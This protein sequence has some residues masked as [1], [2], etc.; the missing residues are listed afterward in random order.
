MRA[1]SG[2]PCW[3]RCTLALLLAVVARADQPAFEPAL[4]IRSATV[5]PAPGA[6]L[7]QAIVL[8]QDGRIVSVGANVRVPPGTREID[9]TGLYVYA[10]FIDA[11][12][13]AGVTEPKP[14]EVQERRVEGEFTSPAE[15]PLTATVEANR[16]GVFAQR[17]VEEL[18][19]V[20]PQTFE[21]LRKAGFTA[22]LLAPPRAVFG[23]Q[24]SVVQL[25]E[26]SLRRSILSSGVAHMA[27]YEVPRRRATR[28]RDTYPGTLFGVV[29][30]LRQTLYDAQ[31]HVSLQ[32]YLEGREGV[33]TLPHDPDLL[34]LAPLLNA[35][36]DVPVA[37]RFMIFEAQ[38]RDDMDRTLRLADEFGLSLVLAGAQEAHEMAATLRDRQVPVIITLSELPKPRAFE[39]ALDK[40][41][42]EPGDLSFFGKNWGKR[43]FQPR[44]AF[45][46]AARLRE[47]VLRNAAVLEAAG[48]R[49]CLSSVELRK[50][51]DALRHISEVVRAGV[52][53]DAALRALTETPARLFGLEAEL[54]AIAPGRRANL[55]LLTAPLGDKQARAR[56]VIVDGKPFEQPAPKAPDKKDEDDEE[57]DD[58]PA[59]TASRPTETQPSQPTPM[60]EVTSAPATSPDPGSASAPSSAS[61]PAPTPWDALLVHEPKWPLETEQ[62][63][64]PALQTG[65]TV[66]LANA[67]VIP[68]VGDDLP[69]ASILV[70][71]GRIA[72]VGTDLEAPPDVKTID[73]SGYVV[74]P[75]IIDPHSH[76]AL[77]EWNEWSLSV[78]PEVRCEDVMRHDDPQIFW[79]LAGGCTTIH[80]MHGSANTIGGQ[81]A[82]IKLKYGRPAA[83]LLVPGRVRTVKWALGENV[84]RP[85][86]VRN[87]W[88]PNA[89]RRFPGTRMGVEATLR[90]ALTAGQQHARARADYQR[91]VAAGEDARPMRHDLRLEALADII[92]GRIQVNT[93]C[94]RADEVLRLIDVAEEFGIR[95]AVLHHVLEAYRIMPEIARHGAGTAS[96]ADWWAYKIEAYNAVPHN[97]AM[98]LR[99]GIAS[100][101]KSDSGDLMR[102]MNIEA[103]KSMRYSGL[104]EIEALRLITLNPARL[105]DLDGRIGSIEVGK[106][107]DLA[108]FDGHPLDTFSRCML[109][110]VDGEVYFQHRDF[111]EAAPPRRGGPSVSASRGK[112]GA[113][114]G[115]RGPGPDS[116]APR[117]RTNVLRAPPA[118]ARGAP[119]YAITRATLHPVSGAPIERGTLVIRGDRI[120][121]VGR[122]TMTDV[123]ADAQITDGSGLHVWPGL[124]NAATQVGM[125][126][127]EAIDV[128]M[129]TSESGSFQPDIQAVSA[130]NPH[131]AMVEVTRAEGITTVALAPN[132]PAIAGQVGVLE[133][134]G[135]TMPEMLRA[136]SMGLV[137]NLPLSKTK[138]IRRQPLPEDKPARESEE[139]DLADEQFRRL[140]RF[141]RDA[142]LYAEASEP[143]GHGD[144]DSMMKRPDPD[145]RFEALRPYLSGE[146]R[147][148]FSA[149]SYQ[150]IL[151]ALIFAEKLELKPLILGG[152]EAWKLADV[153]ADRGVPVIYEGV[154]AMPARAAELDD[155][156]DE[157]DANYRGLATLARAG[158]KFCASYRGADLAKLMPIDVG[159]AVAHGLDPDEAVRSMTL[160]AAEIL[161]LEAELGSLEAGKCANAIVTDGHPCDARTRV[162]Y[163]FIRGQPVSLDSQHTRN[164]D[165]FSQRPAPQLPPERSDLKGPRSRAQPAAAR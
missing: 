98:L 64:R 41:A 5:I 164:A 56:W 25:G 118:P 92:E 22:A 8:V 21:S 79:A 47:R 125:Q 24:A 49:W 2:T 36:G 1:R 14:D 123:P 46:E 13:R 55:T 150:A 15:G 149:N 71:D 88:D 152:R 99:A 102:H 128:T 78:T 165:R 86:K 163:E 134:D 158:V 28:I 113:S 87:P 142:R 93:H 33:E 32:R 74:M 133:L 81:C 17:R 101:L 97:A 18:L 19:D 16:S 117:Q 23:G 141:F 50:P 77:R 96:F 7:E 39:L 162:L 29:A 91:A 146:R 136:T 27:A 95:V 153:L 121:M 137:V 84:I 57:Q 151:E 89:P 26:R 116:A 94:Y 66:L 106:D 145:P 105:F 70:R 159:F 138:P 130:F 59:R 103:A 157:W 120:A 35:R 62:G 131:S 83:E 114:A 80:I 65:G 147:V 124:I 144:R 69:R 129:D 112:A 53:V 9:G 52:E 75:G 38:R 109:T 115:A 61:A 76:I 43:P 10:G 51:Q 48:V 156:T 31:W 37:G 90:R 110:L 143:R 140:E 11:L 104:S 42:P 132:D 67:H 68:V 73:L 122:D 85:G 161:G 20:Q 82:L 100:A 72:A 160:S 154:F 111:S 108:V 34:A 139:K 63:R 148:W 126:E 58:S 127:I 119:A 155:V 135:W 12:S 3:G 30:Q 6:R 44:Q 45:D 40:V 107:G 4:A 60:A 54:G